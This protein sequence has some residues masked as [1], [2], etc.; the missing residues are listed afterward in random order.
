LEFKVTAGWWSCD[1]VYFPS[2]YTSSSTSTSSYAP[3]LYPT[4]CYL[5]IGYGGGP[6]PNGSSNV[7]LST[8][9]SNRKPTVVKT[10]AYTL[11]KTKKLM[12][13]EGKRFAAIVDGWDVG[14]NTQSW[15]AG[16]GR[17][18]GILRRSPRVFGKGNG[19]YLTVITH[20]SLWGV[21]PDVSWDKFTVYG[22][23]GKAIEME[24]NYSGSPWF[25]DVY[26]AYKYHKPPYYGFH[27]QP[28]GE[29]VS[30]DPNGPAANA[31]IKIGDVVTS[32]NLDV[33]TDVYARTEFPMLGANNIP[34]ADF[35][36]RRGSHDVKV[37][38]AGVPDPYWEPIYALYTGSHHTPNF[39]HTE[40]IS[41]KKISPRF[42]PVKAIFTLSC[43]G[44]K[45]KSYPIKLNIPI[46]KE[47]W[48]K[49][50]PVIK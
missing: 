4:H 24:K 31:D 2:S 11:D 5:N 9:V 50:K 21:D 38:I 35:T 22:T 47:F 33:V 25:G 13:V 43:E 18:Y 42:R 17:T 49:P 14:L 46:P 10:F 8:V 27:V 39:T 3:A 23:D 16:Q 37:T 15:K 6:V 1:D 29:V 34:P 40:W 41:S 19:I 44:A 45:I 7:S 20:S 26:E 12:V 30:I 32:N 36:L 28:N 48:E